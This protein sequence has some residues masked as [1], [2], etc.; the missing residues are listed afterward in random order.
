ML[1]KGIFI[2]KKLY[3]TVGVIQVLA[4]FDHGEAM[5]CGRS[6]HHPRKARMTWSQSDHH[7]VWAEPTSKIKFTN[8]FDVGSA[9]AS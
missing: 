6:P 3:V 8:I 5:T 9:H 4:I 1:E 2:E 7:D